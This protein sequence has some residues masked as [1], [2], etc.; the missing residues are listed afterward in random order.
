M[1]TLSTELDTDD[2]LDTRMLGPVPRGYGVEPGQVTKRGSTVSLSTTPLEGTLTH[3]VA[4]WSP[5]LSPRGD[6]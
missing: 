4:P 6:F 3:S 5:S 1:G 2:N